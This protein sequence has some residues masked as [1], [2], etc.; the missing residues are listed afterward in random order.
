MFLVVAGLGLVGP[1]WLFAESDELVR[2]ARAPISVFMIM[3][4]GGALLFVFYARATGLALHQADFD[5]M[6]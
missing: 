3:F 4:S 1:I 6:V 5:V 2:S